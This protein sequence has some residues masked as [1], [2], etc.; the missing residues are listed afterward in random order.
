LKGRSCECVGFVNRDGP[1]IGT[2]EL[3]GVPRGEPAQLFI[4]TD[5]KIGRFLHLTAEQTQANLNLGDIVLDPIVGQA[6]ARLQLPPEN[7]PR[8]DSVGMWTFV[9]E[10]GANIITVIVDSTDGRPRTPWLEPGQGWLPPGRYYVMPNSIGFTGDDT[11]WLLLDLIR[12]GK[13]DDHPELT[14][15]V[16]APNEEVAVTVDPEHVKAKIKAAAQAEGLLSE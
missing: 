6:K 10:D 2:F 16:A 9:S 4:G 15:F 7:P 13:A 1:G 14:S 11:G 5:G 12:A 3:T 8:P